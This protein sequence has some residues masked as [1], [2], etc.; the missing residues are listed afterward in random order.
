MDT[1]TFTA[2][3]NA[4]GVSVP[5]PYALRLVDGK[6]EYQEGMGL[7][8]AFDPQP[9]G[10]VTHLS[11]DNNRVFV[12]LADRSL[13]W[14]VLRTD[15]GAWV[16]YNFRVITELVGSSQLVR[17]VLDLAVPEFDLGPQ[18][19]AFF[20]V[21]D[22][23]PNGLVP[24]IPSDRVQQITTWL[25][26]Y[27]TR[28]E[29]AH[30]A[31]VGALHGPWNQVRR[32][33]VDNLA[34][35][36]VGE[37]A[38]IA[39]G[40]W[41]HTVTTLYVLMEDGRL[42]YV[43]EEP[44]MPAWRAVPGTATT[45]DRREAGLI[46]GPDAILT[47]SHSVV[48]ILRPGARLFSWRRWDYHNSD[49]FAFVP[50]VDWGQSDWSHRGVPLP[51]PEAVFLD[52]SFRGRG[53]VPKP[54]PVP[55]P[56]PFILHF[57]RQHEDYVLERL[58]LFLAMPPVLDAVPLVEVALMLLGFV[59]GLPNE[60]TVA[61][62]GG[63]DL[64]ETARALG[65]AKTSPT[66][67]LLLPRARDLEEEVWF[68]LDEQRVSPV[69][70]TLQLQAETLARR[71]M[72][73]AMILWT[74]VR[75]ACARID[76]WAGRR[77]S[78][79]LFGDNPI[80]PA[81]AYPIE[82]RVRSDDGQIIRSIA[83]DSRS[84]GSLALTAALTMEVPSPETVTLSRSWEGSAQP[85]GE[86]RVRRRLILE[87]PDR[88]GEGA[89]FDWVWKLNDGEPNEAHTKERRIAI[90]VEGRAGD[91]L[92]VT[93][94]AADKTGASIIGAAHVLLPAPKI[95]LTVDIAT[96]H[97]F[98]A[99]S[100]RP[101]ESADGTALAPGT[102]E[103]QGYSPVSIRVTGAELGPGPYRLDWTTTQGRRGSITVAT[104][105]TRLAIPC[106]PQPASFPLRPF[107]TSRRINPVLPTL[108]PGGGF[109]SLAQGNPER[110]TITVT[111][112]DGAGQAA[113]KTLTVQPWRPV[114][115]ESA[116]IPAPNQAP[117]LGTA[118][119]Q[120]SG[121]MDRERLLRELDGLAEAGLVT[122]LEDLQA[123]LGAQAPE[124]PGLAPSDTVAV[125][126]ATISTP[127]I[128]PTLDTLAPVDL[129]PNFQRRED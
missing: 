108:L 48:G 126:M 57:R 85:L 21:G 69:E 111:M 94:L 100:H 119:P 106:T 24:P 31:P 114:I 89:L 26:V 102:V 4:Q 36:D 80:K 104:L 71:D 53:G 51:K 45:E 8:Q 107:N 75:E 38:D 93:L 30:S 87:A 54:W 122:G 90:D 128:S 98:G 109:E 47:A 116:S 55:M 124:T 35:P 129:Q 43:D 123:V 127:V 33:V 7:W 65:T 91:A 81:Q 12:R 50:L 117:G 6:L 64:G 72:G 34:G 41:H 66:L 76:A 1:K 14:C 92:S 120:D 2:S 52:V 95:S 25:T 17:D 29:F 23:W 68:H 22:L 113:Q 60:E 56:H 121:L 115:K 16:D 67:A 84:M 105:P 112:T 10:R 77:S 86:G 49:D 27:R 103:Q 44:M 79:G 110:F 118:Q 46:D 62:A 18:L 82:V 96:S 13:H 32:G 28:L 58:R 15:V 70:D 63:L 73:A 11:A 97:P 19:D 59:T 61:S 42:L 20:S 39:V 83:A 40:N 3:R 99:S 5:E 9:P 125:P 78:V 101:L 37:V 74:I 88:L